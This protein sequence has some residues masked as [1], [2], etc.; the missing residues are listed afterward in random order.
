LTRR[1][2][3]FARESD[4]LRLCCEPYRLSCFFFFVSSLRPCCHTATG[5]QFEC[6]R[7]LVPRT[8]FGRP[9]NIAK[10]ISHA[11]THTHIH[12]HTHTHTH[13]H[14]THTHTHTHT[15]NTHTPHTHPIHTRTLS[16]SLAVCLTLFASLHLSHHVPVAKRESGCEVNCSFFAIFKYGQLLLELAVPIMYFCVQRCS[17]VCPQCAQ[18]LSLSERE[19]ERERECVCVCVCV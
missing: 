8:C 11:H 9:R 1:L 16:L 19:R 12:T 7:V 13:T 18:S 6:D 15:H 5:I 2:E 14:K 10:M 3:I 4:V 17:M